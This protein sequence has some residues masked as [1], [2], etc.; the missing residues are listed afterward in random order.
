MVLFGTYRASNSKYVE[1]AFT[2]VPML[3][4]V[5]TETFWYYLTTFE[6]PDGSAPQ[7]M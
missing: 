4:L 3:I 5:V 7:E 6:Q 2:T 1:K